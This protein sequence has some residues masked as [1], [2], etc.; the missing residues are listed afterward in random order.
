MTKKTML[1]RR[2]QMR[3][4]RQTSPMPLLSVLLRLK[5]WGDVGRDGGRGIKGGKPMKTRKKAKLA[6][7][8]GVCSPAGL[9][10]LPIWV[11]A[12]FGSVM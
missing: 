2:E 6:L 4:T 10:G 7:K 12:T 9:P 1:V 11:A 5:R 3:K 8:A